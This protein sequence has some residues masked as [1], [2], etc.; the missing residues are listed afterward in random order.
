MESE[1]NEQK[2]E[3]AN[4]KKALESLEYQVGEAHHKT[5]KKDEIIDKQNR[6]IVQKLEQIVELKKE[7]C[8]LQRRVRHALDEKQSQ[9]ESLEVKLQEQVQTIQ[10]M[11]ND[12]VEKEES[13]LEQNSSIP[14][15]LSQIE[16]E[17]NEQKK[18][19]ANLKKT[20]ESLEC[21]VGEARHKTTEKDEIIEKQ[22]RKI[23]QN[24]ELIVELKKEICILQRKVRQALD[25]KKSQVESV[26]AKFQE[27]VQTI[28]TMQHDFQ[29]MEESL[30]EQNSSIAAQLSQIESERNEQEKEI[31]NLKKA[32]E[33]LEYQVGEAHHKT[34]KDEIID[35]Q[36]REIVQKLEQIVELKKE[37]CILQRRVRH[38]LDEK[39]SQVESL[40]AK[41][42]EQVQTIQMMHNDFQEKEES[43]L[44][45]NSSIAVQLSQIESER[46]EQ[47]KE[48]TNLKKTLESLECQVGEAH[49]ERTKKDEII[50]NQI[51][52][53]V[54]KQELIVELKKEIC[55]LQHKVRQALDEKKSQVE[56]VE[57]KF[58]EQVQTIQTM[59]HDFQ[60]MEESLLEQ[61]SSIAAQLSQTESERNE[62]E[63]EIANLKKTVESLEC[64]V[65]EAHIERRKKDEIIENQIREIL[66]NQERIVELE[67]HIESMKQFGADLKNQ[68]NEHL[69]AENYA[70]KENEEILTKKNETLSAEL[71]LLQ[72]ITE[73]KHEELKN[74]TQQIFRLENAV[75]DIENVK[76]AQLESVKARSQAEIKTIQMS[77]HELQ[78]KEEFLLEQN[79]S[80]DAERNELKKEN[81]ILRKGLENLEY[82]VR[83][84]ENLTQQM[85]TLEEIIKKQNCKI[86]HMQ[87]LID[88]LSEHLEV[89]RKINEN[90]KDQLRREEE[91]KNYI[92]AHNFGDSCQ[93]TDEPL[94]LENLAPEPEDLDSPVSEP[95]PDVVLTQENLAPEPEEL[96]SPVSE[97]P[98]DVVPTSSSWRHGARRLLKVGLG[99][100]AAG[101]VIPAAYWAFSMFNN[102][103]PYDSVYGGLEPYCYLGHGSVPL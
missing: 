7:I 77:L 31:A 11:H 41:L 50:E 19:I 71:A 2:K 66:Q 16:S 57:A 76:R 45:Q 99:L 12:F 75:K 86:V 98:P 103:S 4:L 94:Q 80:I 93:I 46:N 73:K 63:K 81:T 42:Q 22:N 13:L 34:K 82:Q 36:N 5:T 72:T 14:V 35:K 23:V 68:L 78:Q 95:S 44:E 25:E 101:I 24:Q 30:L 43:L 90:L 9:V 97:S 40:E 58:Q 39:Q 54:Q 96:D 27:Q 87:D 83:T 85:F 26:E 28:Q 17:K 37:I 100:A 15:Q 8:I 62:Q 56:S 89:K 84:T 88:E 3:N 18:E 51:R 29:E 52:E 64:Q 53:I 55:I 79:S 1:R 48:I 20:L 102:C 70:L 65:G 21:Q 38:A 6:E 49:I 69:L 32:L 60:E 47:K 91:E 59:Q 61:N 67:E 74:L 10:T 92:A 33:S